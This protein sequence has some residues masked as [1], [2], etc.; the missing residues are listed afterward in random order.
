M[1]KFKTLEE[2]FGSAICGGPAAKMQIFVKTL[3]RKT[4]TLEDE[5]LDTI[6]NVKTKIQYKE[7]IP[8]GRQRLTFAGKHL[9]DGHSLSDYNIQK[10]ITLY[11]ALRLRGGA[12]ER[13]KSY[14]PPKKN[15]HQRKKRKLAV[16]Q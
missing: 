8:P 2:T 10:E 7:G 16:L 13:K 11:L 1:R 3:M 15:K 14:T 6:E 5:P 4:I 9:G 12:R